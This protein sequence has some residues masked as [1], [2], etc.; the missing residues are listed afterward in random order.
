MEKKRCNKNQQNSKY[1][2]KQASNYHQ[3]PL[4][5]QRCNIATSR[6]VFI[7]ATAPQKPAIVATGSLPQK[8]PTS[9]PKVYRGQSTR[10]NSKWTRNQ[11]VC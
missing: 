6:L 3:F 2:Q 10:S 9:S 1:K 4:G 11:I 7:R 8:P 5:Q